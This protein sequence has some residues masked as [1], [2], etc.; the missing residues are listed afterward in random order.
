MAKKQWLFLVCFAELN[1]VVMR[2]VR[3]EAS[4][5]ARVEET[6]RSDGSAVEA[7]EERFCAGNNNLVEVI[8]PLL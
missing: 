1:T 8:K 7:A 3:H 5:R 4:S 2:A 6:G